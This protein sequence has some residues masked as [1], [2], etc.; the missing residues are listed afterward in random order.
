MSQK[1]WFIILATI[2]VISIIGNVFFAYIISQ[3][4]DNVQ[5]TT[6][7]TETNSSVNTNSTANGNSDSDTDT[8][9]STDSDTN[10]DANRSEAKGLGITFVYPEGW[11]WS[12][13]GSKVVMA[14][15]KNFQDI[16]LGNRPDDYQLIY[17]QLDREN[18]G[19]SI[20]AEPLVDTIQTAD[21][22]E[23]SLY[24][25]Y[26][27]GGGQKMTAVWKSPDGKAYF[28]TTGSPSL[29]LQGEITALK[30]VIG[31]IKHN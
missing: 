24:V 31:T 2:L 13:E 27:E 16:S 14:N 5:N 12:S 29:N 19:D 8:N 21:G 4:D 9:S 18:Y 28:G 11:Y 23:V 20:K 10:D 15:N 7:T 3:D 30:K 22:V 6:E 26:T 1:H 25:Y 17:F